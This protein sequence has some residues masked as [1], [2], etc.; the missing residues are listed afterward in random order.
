M[1]FTEQVGQLVRRLTPRGDLKVDGET[2][3]ERSRLLPLITHVAAS[4]PVLVVEATRTEA[5]RLAEELFERIEDGYPSP[6]SLV[7]TVRAR[8]GNDHLLSKTLTKGVAFHHS[9]LPV[10]IQAELEDAVRAGDIRCLIATTTLTEGVNFPFK[11]V[12]IGHRGYQSS[13]GYVELVDAACLLNAIGRAGRA[14]RESEGW[15]I[16]SEHFAFRPEM[17]NDL[18]G[19]GQTLSVRSTL[20]DDAVLVALARFEELSQTSADEILAN[21]QAIADGF[22]SY[23]WF[24]ADALEEL[25]GS[26]DQEAVNS[27]IRDTL[28]WRQAD[29]AIQEQF[30][31]ITDLSFR[32][33]STQTAG[34]RRRWARAGTS[35]PYAATLES[36]SDSVFTTLATNTE[37]PDL[38]SALQ[39]IIGEGRLATILALGENPK[40]GFK[41]RRNDPRNQIINVNVEGL[42]LSWL[43]GQELQALSEEFLYEIPD[44]EYRQGQLSE[45][46]ASV[47]EHHIPWITGIIIGWVNSRL[48][49]SNNPIRLP[50]S[51]PG[52]IHFGV[53]SLDGLTLMLGGIRSR[54]LANRVASDHAAEQSTNVLQTL[55]GWLASQDI[56]AWKE[57]FD[58]S[59]TE[60]LDL[61]GYS[62]NP[63]AR[64]VSDVL[65]GETYTVQFNL[66]APVG[67]GVVASIEPEANETPPAPLVIVVNGTTVGRIRLQDHDDISLLMRIGIPLDITVRTTDPVAIEIRLADNP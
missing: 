34:R 51:L 13:E 32:S 36:I 19:P 57:R 47:F 10:D 5:Q 67:D 63:E 18:E 42:L 21:D 43:A 65:D 25:N 33:F 37:A 45:F 8:L 61:L 27:V 44:P 64:L 14:G 3:T 17:F 22:V 2:T 29:D 49:E 53:G 54:R 12:I 11:T 35:L 66:V 38:A 56:T 62:R 4:G 48:E 1:Q 28:A 20:L 9:A 16:L 7:D 40:Q 41:A 23:I 26:V 58:A 46:I 60:I 6:F 50:D 24:V 31:R 55:R 59:P 52:A 39:V 15:L 30:L